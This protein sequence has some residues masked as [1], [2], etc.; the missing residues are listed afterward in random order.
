MEL[1]WSAGCGI[2][3]CVAD[4]VLYVMSYFLMLKRSMCEADHTSLSNVV[5]KN[6]GKFAN[7][8]H[9]GLFRHIS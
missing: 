7:G 4:P 9:S 2:K 1:T 3:F 8:L 6:V 5:S